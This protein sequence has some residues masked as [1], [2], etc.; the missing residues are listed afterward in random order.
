MKRVLCILF[1]IAIYSCVHAQ[2]FKPYPQANISAAQSQQYFD[3]VRQKYGTTAQNLSDQQI[4]LFT[5]DA[6]R[7][8]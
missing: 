7:T 1:F 8:Y 4:I 3:E 5:D 2:E 6:S